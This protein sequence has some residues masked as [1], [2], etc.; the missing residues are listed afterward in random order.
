MGLSNAKIDGFLLSLSFVR[1]KSDP[2]VYLKLI[3]GSFMIILLYVDDPFI[4]R[5]SKKEIVSLIIPKNIRKLIYA[6][7]SL[8]TAYRRGYSLYSRIHRDVC[9]I[10]ILLEF[11]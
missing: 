5:S 7:F 6:A 3:H 10:Q 11:P 8:I 1:C 9:I 4:T 2:N